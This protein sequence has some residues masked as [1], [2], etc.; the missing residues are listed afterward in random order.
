MGCVSVRRRRSWVGWGA[1]GKGRGVR[2]RRRG[3]YGISALLVLPWYTARE[4]RRYKHSDCFRALDC[5]VQGRIPISIAT[6]AF[7]F[8]AGVD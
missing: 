3:A 1:G 8:V 6:D 5:N 4:T 2:G 7:V